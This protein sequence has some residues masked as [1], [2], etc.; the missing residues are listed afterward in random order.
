MNTISWINIFIW[1]L[2]VSDCH[3]IFIK[4]ENSFIR[5]ETRIYSNETE[6]LINNGKCI[7]YF[8]LKNPG[9]ALPTKLDEFLPVK[10]NGDRTI[11]YLRNLLI[12]L[13]RNDLCKIDSDDYFQIVNLFPVVNKDLYVAIAQLPKLIVS[14][15]LLIEKL[16]PEAKFVYFGWG[17]ENQLNELRNIHITNI[18][19][20]MNAKL[21]YIEYCKNQYSRIIENLPTLESKPKHIQ[22]LPKRLLLNVLMELLNSK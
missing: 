21:F 12:E 11:G 6:H 8:Y 20:P 1:Y 9:S 22:G 15:N 4:F 17:S 19:F 13:K 5:Y 7:G 10:L 3:A 2:Y 14:K 16:K 18:S